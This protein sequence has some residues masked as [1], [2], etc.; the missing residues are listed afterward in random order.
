MEEEHHS[1]VQHISTTQT[2]RDQ[3]ETEGMHH[4]CLHDVTTTQSPRHK[5]ET[6]EFF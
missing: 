5:N 1:S 4:I 6:E 2:L 3:N